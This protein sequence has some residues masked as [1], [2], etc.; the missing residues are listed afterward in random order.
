MRALSR[1]YEQGSDQV[2]TRPTDIGG[3]GK[4]P[5]KF[6][7]AVNKL[8]QER[9]IEGRR[10]HEGHM[11]LAINGHRVGDVRRE[12]RPLW[13]RPSLWAVVVLVAVAVSAGFAI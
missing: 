12:L 10:D 5:E 2:L 8:L 6:Q 9:L 1:K 3:F 4:S 7:K 11:A 13:A